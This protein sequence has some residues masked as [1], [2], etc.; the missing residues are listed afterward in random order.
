MCP[1]ADP[2]A[3]AFVQSFARPGGNITGVTTATAEL[4]GKNLDL[5]REVLPAV[6]RVG[7]VRNAAYPFHKPYLATSKPR[8]EP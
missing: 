3:T 4:A 7:V 5:I 1:A 2:I 8:P 6:L